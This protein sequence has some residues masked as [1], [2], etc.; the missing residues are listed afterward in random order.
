MTYR[1]VTDDFTP[2]TIAAPRSNN[3]A[4]P[5]ATPSDTSS[6]LVGVDDSIES[7]NAAAWA[8]GEALRRGSDLIVLHAWDTTPAL[9]YPDGIVPPH[10]LHN[11]AA[12]TLAHGV[13]AAE[14]V[15]VQPIGR[16]V[17]GDPV[18]AL[19]RAAAHSSLL[20]LGHH[21]RNRLVSLLRRSV[22]SRCLRHAPCPVVVVGAGLAQPRTAPFRSRTRR[23]VAA[24]GRHP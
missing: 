4:T 6:L 21:R 14:N 16:L 11:D 23:S 12:A 13:S 10:Y 24:G 18:D 2:P 3:Q 19:V 15:G 22:I 5:G 9:G 7:L 1:A 8:A 20:V 17:N